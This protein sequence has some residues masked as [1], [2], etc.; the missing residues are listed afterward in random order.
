M[1]YSSRRSEETVEGGW[2]RMTQPCYS[3]CRLFADTR[4]QWELYSSLPGPFKSLK[5]LTRHDIHCQIFL[6][7]FS[8]HWGCRN[9]RQKTKVI[10][11]GSCKMPHQRLF[12][13]WSGA[14]L[15]MPNAG[16]NQALKLLFLL[17]NSVIISSKL[18]CSPKTLQKIG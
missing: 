18:F 8:C 13:L 7:F 11:S 9:R 10:R 2:G 12:C 1:L 14:D 5:Y 3:A 16:V 6:V 4:R 15:H 17:W